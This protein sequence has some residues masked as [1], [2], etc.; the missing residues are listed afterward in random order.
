MNH[1]SPAPAAIA[2]PTPQELALSGAW[3]ARGIGALQPQ[4]VSLRATTAGTTIADGS[5][6]EALDTAGAWVLQKLL[7]RLRAEGTDVSLQGLRPEFAK[8]LDAVG[9][10]QAG[11]EQT[12]AAA[13]A[14]ASALEG[15][16]RGAE[17][18]FTQV[19]ALLG[20]VGESA[21]ALAQSVAHP[22]RIR[23]RPI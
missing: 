12:S 20:F 6:I 7:L 14:P 19:A 13:P 11:H 15:I 9:E 17:A 8:L 3:T 2:Q 16:G 4:L 5:G 10:Q 21:V 18:A 1:V 22:Q 23:W